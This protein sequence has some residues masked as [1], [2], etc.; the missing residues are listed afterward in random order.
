MKAGAYAT[1]IA[2]EVR[3]LLPVWV[4]SGLVLV[5]DA[6]FGPVRVIP[7]GLLAYGVGA[8]ALGA[9][10]IGHEHT[11]RTL[12]ILLAQPSTRRRILLI[13]QSVLAAMLLSLFALAEAVALEGGHESQPTLDEFVLIVM[14][15]LCGLFVAPWL[16]MIG[17]NPLHGAVFSVAI[18][19]SLLLAGELIGDAL[20]GAGSTEVD[21]FRLAF[22]SRTTLA[23]C[24]VAA[25]LGWRKF[26]R[27]E[28]IDAAHREIAMPRWLRGEERAQTRHP[29]WMLAKK[30]L[31]LQ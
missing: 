6:V 2:K 28:V 17:R 8:V 26:L 25:V 23:L 9:L 16:T 22:W 4:V 18:P 14:P 30:E 21:L 24:A 10:S 1:T 5:A 11:H 19:G 7:L 31:R 12:G 20:F 13:K 15:T 27:L 3:A 29:L